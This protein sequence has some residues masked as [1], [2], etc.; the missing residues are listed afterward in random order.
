MVVFV[1]IFLKVTISKRLQDTDCN[2]NLG[3]YQSNFRSNC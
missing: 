1:D 2:E 3:G